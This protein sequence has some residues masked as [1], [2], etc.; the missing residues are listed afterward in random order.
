MLLTN[1]DF[2][3]LYALICRI[4]SNP[5][6]SLI[7]ALEAVYGC[8]RSKTDGTEQ[9]GCNTVRK[10]LRPFFDKDSESVGWVFAD[11]IYTANIRLMKND[12]HYLILAAAVAEIRDAMQKNDT[13]RIVAA[14]DAI[15]NIPCLLA[16]E[17]NPKKAVFIALSGY[18]DHYNRDFLVDEMK[19]L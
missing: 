18:R 4:R 13:V 8:V 14:A 6:V 16:D 5:D 1:Y 3:D 12:V 15:H 2:Y 9:G 17:K 10:L 11:N 19:A 7:P